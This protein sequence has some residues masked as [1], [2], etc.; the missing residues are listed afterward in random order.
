MDN[1]KKSEQSKSSAAV[2]NENYNIKKGIICILIAGMGFSLMTAFVRLS[3]SLP[4]FEKAFFRNFVA[5]IVSIYLIIKKGE[6]NAG[7][8]KLQS[9]SYLPLLVRCTAGTVGIICN[10]WAVDHIALA[11]ANMLNKMS[12]FFCMIFAAIL[13]KDMPKHTDILCIIMAIFGAVFVVKPGS[14]LFQPGSLVGLL[15]GLGAGLAY[16]CV[17]ILGMQHVKGEVIVAAFSI[18]SSL[19]CLPIIIIDHEPMSLYQLSMLILAGCSAAAAQLA[20]TAAYTYAPPKEISVYDYSQVIYAAL[21]AFI[22]WGEIPDYYS[23]AGYI[24][25]IAA[26]ILHWRIQLNDK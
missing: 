22:V 10:F 6:L 20:I 3:G 16:C 9:K 5:A 14:S 2:T 26:A 8:L 13:L 12:P 17:R 11:D 25:I 21:I 4:T 15:G 18:F 7:A 19:V 24:I 1:D 23:I